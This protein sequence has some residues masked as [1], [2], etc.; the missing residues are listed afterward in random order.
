VAGEELNTSKPNDFRLS[1]QP[2]DILE[3]GKDNGGIVGNHGQNF[4]LTVAIK[5]ATITLE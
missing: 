4:K 1:A 3:V 5:S 2:I